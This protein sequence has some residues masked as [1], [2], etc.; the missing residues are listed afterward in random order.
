HCLRRVYV[1]DVVCHNSKTMLRMASLGRGM[2]ETS[3][4]ATGN[5]QGT[6]TDASTTNPINGA[7]VTAGSNTTTTNASGFYQFAG[8]PT[9]TYSVTASAAGYTNNTVA[10]VVVNDSATT[11]QNIALTPA[12]T[13]GCLTDT[14]QADFQAGIATSVDLITSP[15][16]VTLAAGGAVLDQQQTTLSTSG[17]AITTATWE[18]QSFVP[19]ISGK[20][21]QIDAALF[22]SACTG[23]TQPVTVEV[24]TTSAGLPTATVLASTTIPGF[25]SGAT[26]F[27]SASFSTPATVTA[28]TTY[29]YV[30]RMQTNPSPG[31]YAAT[32]SSNN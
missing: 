14:S 27:Y 32:R 20:L 17:N 30:L 16:N 18:G 11:T 24:R 19:A 21:M 10:G 9:G 22:C 25:S 12:P 6:V 8:I 5:L 26:T 15:G 7:T 2:W 31:T 4:G 13:S 23:T 1:C 28:G 3:V 29:A